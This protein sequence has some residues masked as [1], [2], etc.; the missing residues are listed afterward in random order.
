MINDSYKNKKVLVFGLGINQGGV[1]VTR[2]FAQAE[3]QVRITDLKTVDQL[4]VSMDQLKQFPDIEYTLG[5]HKYEDIDWADLIIKN[6][7][8]KEGNPY[9]EYA[10]QKGKQI[11]MDMGIF[12]QFAKPSQIIGVTG[13]KGKSTT[14][15]LIY[16]ALKAG[17][18]N[19]VFAGN[20]GK[21]V[22]DTIS[23]ITPNTL[24]VLELSSFQLEA[25]HQHRVSPKWAV[26]TNIYPDHLNYYQTMEQYIEAKKAITAY[27]TEEDI[28][29]L[30]KEDTVTNNTDFLRGIR[31]RIIH[32]SPQDFTDE[33]KPK[34]IGEHNRANLAASFAVVKVF[35][36]PEKAALDVLAKFRGVEFRLQLIKEWNGVKIYNDTSSTGPDSGIQALK[37]LPESIVICGGVNKNLPYDKYAQSLATSAKKIFFLEGDATIEVRSLLNSK[38][39]NQKSKLGGTYNNLEELLKDVKKEIKFGDTILF[40]PAA[41]SFNLFQNEFDRG[42]KFNQA[43]EKIFNSKEV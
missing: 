20:I 32:F 16:E 38:F 31:A 10:K 23:H 36:I 39:K 35:D 8:I 42:R 1:G 13:T 29:F 21:S 15:S 33:F 40:S 28:L 4:K 37:A 14:A 25:F 7:A 12:L 9:M 24:I 18:K 26:I 43:V 3:A 22:M 5:E 27:Q 2:F 17:G 34:L 6:P 41:A 19:I 30:N 11:E